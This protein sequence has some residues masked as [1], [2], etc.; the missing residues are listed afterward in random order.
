MDTKQRVKPGILQ[1]ITVIDL[2]CLIA[3]PYSAMVMADLG[4]RV[5]K[6]EALA[7]EDG[8]HFGPPSYAQSS[9][10]FLACNRGKESIAIDLRTP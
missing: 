9:V 7:D 4:A 1:G 6:V 2:S 10:T 3:G 8:R 5:I